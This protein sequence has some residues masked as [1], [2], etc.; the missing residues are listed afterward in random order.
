MVIAVIG[1]IGIDRYH[2]G[3]VRGISAEAP[4][5][6][7]DIKGRIDRPGM[8]ANVLA[9]LKFLGEDSFCISAAP[10]SKCPIKNR[11]VT[12]DGHQLARWDEHD[13]C[14]PYDTDQ[15]AALINAD[16][17]IVCDYGK[18]SITPDVISYLRNLKIQVFVDT[19]GDPSPWIGS[20]AILFPNQL[21]YD[22]YA[23]KYGW[24]GAVV[25]KKGAEGLAYMEFGS[26]V[27]TRPAT[28]VRVNCV[29]GAG[30]TLI[31]AFSIAAI[32]G[33]SLPDCMDIANVAAGITVEQHF[34]ARQ[35]SLKT[36]IAR[37][38]EKGFYDNQ[39]ENA[40]EGA[41]GPECT[42]DSGSTNPL[43]SELR[44]GYESGIDPDLSG[45]TGN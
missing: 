42:C 21:E 39:S 37:L 9:N 1:D 5:P 35:P 12:E 23:D 43:S 18:G 10:D 16:A 38:E 3:R 19:K 33:Q 40:G 6:I 29:N 13:Y 25:L 17:V 15:L 14:P 27:L 26:I 44:E 11:L 31:A 32:D 22:R 36:V 8:A 7:V 30:D 28:A 41:S 2:I 34:L 20:D 45:T 24:L 4:I